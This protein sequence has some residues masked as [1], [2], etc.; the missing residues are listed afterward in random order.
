MEI[1]DIVDVGERTVSPPVMNLMNSFY[2]N[3]KKF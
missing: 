1:S 2:L 3:F